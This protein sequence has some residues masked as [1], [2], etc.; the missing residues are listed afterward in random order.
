V[1]LTVERFETEVAAVRPGFG[2][3][4]LEASK[5]THPV[6]GMRFGIAHLAVP[7]L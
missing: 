5:S 7:A 3:L 6:D 1:K 4:L 2:I